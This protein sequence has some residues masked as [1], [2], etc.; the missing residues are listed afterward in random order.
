MQSE[1]DERTVVGSRPT[2]TFGATRAPGPRPCRRHH[3]AAAPGGRR[4]AT[5]PAA[6][7]RARGPATPRDTRA[8]LA[9]PCRAAPADAGRA[10]RPS[11]RGP[12]IHHGLRRATGRA[13]CDGRRPR[14]RP[15]RAG[16]ARTGGRWGAMRSSGVRSSMRSLSRRETGGGLELGLERAQV[17][18]HAPCEQSGGERPEATGRPG[19]ALAADPPGQ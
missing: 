19:Q 10:G 18:R 2:D 6:R 7:R 15:I 9:H 14:F 4:R 11:D 13:G 8:I 1:G 17:V 3:R 12:R 5:P 16:R